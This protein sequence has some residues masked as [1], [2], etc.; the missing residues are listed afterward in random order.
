MIDEL[1]VVVHYWQ[2]SR[3]WRQPS[4]NQKPLANCNASREDAPPS[5]GWV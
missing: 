2:Y 3:L 1:T 4:L 5:T